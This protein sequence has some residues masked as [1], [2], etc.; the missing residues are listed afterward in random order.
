MSGDKKRKLPEGWKWEKLE[1]IFELKYGSGLPKDIRKKGD[2]PVFG[3]NGIVGYNS[4]SITNGS[5]IIIGRKGSAGEVV[6]SNVACWPID[7]TYYIDALKIKSNLKYI[8]YSLRF[9][10]LSEL[11]KSS[12][13]PGL[14]RDDVYSIKICLPSTPED[15][16][17]IEAD[18]E[19]RMAQVEKMRGAALRQKE[20]ISAMQGAILREVFQYKEGD[21]LPE[22]WRWDM[23]ENHISN[24][25]SGIA[26]GEKS[27]KAGYPHMRMN[28]ISNNMKLDL[29][30]LWRI[31]ASE[32]EIESYSLQKGDILFNNT[33]SADLVGKSCLFDID[34]NETFLFS[35]HLT[36]IRTRNSL[37]A[38]Y[39][40]YWINFLWQK[41]YFKDNCDKWV[42]QAA[43][44]VE[45]W[46]FPFDIPLPPTIAD[47]LAITTKLERKMAE[48]E[49]ARQATEKQ[50]EAIEAL[51]GAI[52]R[53][54]FDFVE[55]NTG[56]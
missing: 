52:L 34:S 23:I 19:H 51:P 20:G 13:V 42:N 1:N 30:F 22:G 54:V 29:K 25:Q 11:D 7:T 38:K 9:L 32:K 26:C 8:Y 3:S 5:T 47:Q 28:N 6:W 46:I 50:F 48:L 44:R 15:Q 10:K 21:E 37:D 55:E 35:N 24:S 39:L 36:R 33:N 40:L 16:D 18:L 45:D 14:N 49:K 27:R 12:A 4:E 31:P 17:I 53:E 2:F 41:Q 56:A 43:I